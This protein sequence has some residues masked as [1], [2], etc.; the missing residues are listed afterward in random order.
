M[1][2]EQLGTVQRGAMTDQLNLRVKIKNEGIDSTRSAGGKKGELRRD[3]ISLS[4]YERM[5]QRGFR[6]SLLYRV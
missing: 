3:M 6:Q 1:G 2:K 5:V 4:V